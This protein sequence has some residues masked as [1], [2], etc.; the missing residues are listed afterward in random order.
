MRYASTVF[1]ELPRTLGSQ[2]C[3]FSRA[4]L[5]RSPV[6]RSQAVFLA[7]PAVPP[8]ATHAFGRSDGVRVSVHENRAMCT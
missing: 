7:L 1:G 3:S 8:L 6:H 2:W 5:A 4:R